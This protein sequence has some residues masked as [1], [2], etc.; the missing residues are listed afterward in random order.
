MAKKGDNLGASDRENYRDRQRELR[1]IKDLQSEIT[2][3]YSSFFELIKQTKNLKQEI[4]G[5]ENQIYEFELEKEKLLKDSKKKNKDEIKLLDQRIYKTQEELRLKK[6]ILRQNTGINNVLKT[7]GHIAEKWVSTL[8]FVPYILNEAD[9]AIKNVAKSIGVAGENADTLRNNIYKAQQAAVQFGSTI[10]S[11]SDIQESFSTYTSQARALNFEQLK[12]LAII[13][14]GTGIATDNVGMLASQFD[15]IGLNANVTK[16]VIEET[17]NNAEMMAVNANNVL[18]KISQNMGKLQQYNFAN[19]IRGLREMVTFSERMKV[20]IDEVFGSIDSFRNLESAVETAAILQ[21]MGGNFANADPFQM[22]FLAR[23]KPEEFAKKMNQM[24]EGITTFSDKTGEVLTPSAVNMDRLRIVADQTG[25]SIENLVTQSMN[26]AQMKRVGRELIGFSQ[27]DVELVSQ[28]AK[29]NQETNRFEVDVRGQITDVRD[30]GQSQLEMLRGT[31][32]TLEN[33]A[34]DAMDFNKVLNVTVEEL[35]SGLLPLL[36][37]LNKGIHFIQDMLNDVRQTFGGEGIRY[38]SMSLLS[39]AGMS[40]LWRTAKSAGKFV[41]GSG[42]MFGDIGSIFKSKGGSTGETSKDMGNLGSTLKNIPSAKTLLAKAAGVAAI[43]VAAAGIGAGIYLAAEGISSLGNSLSNLNNDQIQSLGVG[44]GALT[45]SIAG[46]TAVA[47]IF[48]PAAKPLLAFGASVALIGAGIGIAAAGIGMMSEGL[49]KLSDPTIG[50]N[51]L[52]IGQGLGVMSLA[53]TN[54]LM[55]AGIGG[56]SVLS[57]LNFDDMNNAFY[58]ASEFLKTDSSNLKELKNTLKMLSEVDSSNI[59]RMFEALT[60]NP[61]KVEFSDN[62]K[63]KFNA[64]ITL[65]LDKKI[66]LKE[67]NL[68]KELAI[69]TEN[70]KRGVG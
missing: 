6:E 22:G 40:A 57:L 60:K 7:T 33:R 37:Q 69:Q 42:S 8:G 51:M 2:R 10:S 67:L 16:D 4:L 47:M 27:K 56:L 46:L 31:Q 30:L 70:I 18:S 32:K 3:D 36:E 44:F 43:G 26:L 49:S 29:F 64:D 45:A 61:L 20:N 25:R 62:Q 14:E 11:I 24:L 41:G 12:S 1:K 65:K 58:N 21:T 9:Y 59:N 53:F 15:L 35:K 52:K 39:I 19:G 5:I 34:K 13:K 28:L 66:L 48:A 50:E 63:A 23:N 55:L 68:T 38:F 54:P 17:F